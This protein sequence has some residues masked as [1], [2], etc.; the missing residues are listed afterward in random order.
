MLLQ[1][2]KERLIQQLVLIQHCLA[3]RQV[4]WVV[5]GSTGLLLRGLPLLRLPNDL[6]IYADDD[7]AL[8]IHQVLA[9]FAIDEQQLSYSPIYR[10]LLSHYHFDGV[11]VELVGGFQVRAQQSYYD[12]E[13]T[14]FLAPYSEQIVLGESTISVVPLAH[15]LLF[16]VLRERDDRV[17]LIA[18]AMKA[19]MSAHFPILQKL[20]KRNDIS[21]EVKER[22]HGELQ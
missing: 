14:H 1:M 12:V 21:N 8:I 17:A 16:N 18:Q 22:I 9:S 15:E 10:S 4:Q 5:G 3:S 20:M 19:D 7:H 6:D 2:T 11:K 13:V